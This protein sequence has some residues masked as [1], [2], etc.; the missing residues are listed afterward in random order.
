MIQH[1]DRNNL[2]SE[3]LALGAD[4]FGHSDANGMII[5]SPAA[6]T[7]G[8]WRAAAGPGSKLPVG[9]ASVSNEA[10]PRAGGCCRR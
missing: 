7:F 4:A 9:L 8:V 5:I 10:F 1:E 2:A 6:I 3:M